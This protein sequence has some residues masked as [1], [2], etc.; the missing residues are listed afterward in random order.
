MVYELNQ[1]S[2][3]VAAAAALVKE[4][5]IARLKRGQCGIP[6]A[7]SHVAR[8]ARLSAGV[9]RRLW[10]PSRRPKDIGIGIV[11]RLRDA[12]SRFLKAQIVELERRVALV[13]QSHG[14]DSA[15]R[16]HLVGEAQALICRI[17]KSI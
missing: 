2:D 13:E 6:R 16:E 14:A 8:D 15:A 12:E 5:V 11:Q 17:K 3:E 7:I 10:H 1:L 4:L 9:V